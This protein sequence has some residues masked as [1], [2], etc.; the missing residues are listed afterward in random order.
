MGLRERAAGI[1]KGF[2][3][4]KD[5]IN[6]YEGLPDGE[7]RVFV[8]NV[9]HSDYD[10]LSIKATVVEGENDGRIEFLNLGLDEVTSSGKKIPDFVIDRNIKT[11][12]KLGLVLGIAI[13]DD[14]WDDMNLLV[15]EFKPA[16]GK[17]FIMH[18][19]N[20]ENKKNPAYPYKQY[21]F[22]KYVEDPNESNG[23]EISD[24]DVPF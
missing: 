10:Q 16:V 22:E 9:Q 5:D 15:E 8:S 12:M 2:D 6:G 19:E 3:A 7:Y 20:R 21:E 13:T 17:Q 11:I 18:L 1:S 4:S 24:D 14:A 23:I